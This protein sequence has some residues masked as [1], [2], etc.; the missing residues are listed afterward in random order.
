MPVI[1]QYAAQLS[2]PGPTQG[3]QVTGQQLGADV[4]A[5]VAGFGQVLTGTAGVMAKRIE[6]EETSEITAKTTSKYA[7]LQVGLQQIIRKGGSKEEFDQYEEYAGE[8]LTKI[9]EEASTPAAK[10]YLAEASAQIK[11]QLY[12]TSYAGQADLAGQKAVNNY[13]TS[14]NKLSAATL[15]DPSAMPL[16]RQLHNQSIDALVSTNQMPYAQGEEL[17]LQG[18]SAI[19]K[20]GLRSWADLNPDFAKQKLDSGEFD[21]AIGAEGTIRGKVKWAGLKDWNYF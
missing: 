20:S 6:Q 12:K 2:A 9:G 16:N 1:R 21:A 13:T 19:V 17:K 14:L 18:D 8:E 15:A 7:E 5:A 3:P 4:G 10:Q 11:G